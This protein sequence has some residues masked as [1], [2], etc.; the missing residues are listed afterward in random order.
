VEGG[1]RCSSQEVQKRKDIIKM[2]G[3]YNGWILQGRASGGKA[4]WPLGWRSLDK[5]TVCA[6]Q[7]G[8]VTGRD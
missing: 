7:E 1:T 2:A 5:G 8:P 4:A 3:F 6:S